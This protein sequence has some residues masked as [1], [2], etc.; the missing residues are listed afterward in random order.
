MWMWIENNKTCYKSFLLYC[1][2]EEKTFRP[3]IASTITGLANPT[4][5]YIEVIVAKGANLV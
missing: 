1:V 3:V 5:H 4:Q 2:K